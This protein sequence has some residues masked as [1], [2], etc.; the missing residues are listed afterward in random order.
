MFKTAYTKALE[1]RIGDLRTEHVGEVARLE[2]RHAAEVARYH[3]ELTELRLWAR[4][5]VDSVMMKHGAW[6]VSVPPSV[7]SPDPPT[8]LVRAKGYVPMAQ[9]AQEEADEE[10][11]AYLEAVAGAREG[12]A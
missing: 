5:L 12:E 11:Q 6:P 7:L 4:H 9:A 1:E 3:A 10:Y 2:A 8:G